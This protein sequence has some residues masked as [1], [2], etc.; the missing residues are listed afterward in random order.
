MVHD[1]IQ[2]ND[3]QGISRRSFVEKSLKAG[4]GVLGLAAGSGAIV[5][6]LSGCGGAASADFS[7]TSTPDATA[8][9]HLVTIS[10]TDVDSPPDQKIL[11][12]SATFLH[13]HEVTMTKADYDAIDGGQTV[14]KTCTLTGTPPHTHTFS[15]KRP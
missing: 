5:T 11:T 3:T 10:G 12:S 7:V 8:H 1:T 2:F 9:S 14:S 6:L 13:T 4:A 15:I